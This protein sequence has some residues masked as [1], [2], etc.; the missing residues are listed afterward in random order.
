MYYYEHTNG[1]VISKTD[2]VV[3]AS[4]GPGEYFDSPFVVR[5]WHEEDKK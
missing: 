1:T 4:G 3:N 2:Y 5:W